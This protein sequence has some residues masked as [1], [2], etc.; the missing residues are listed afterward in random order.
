[1]A[2]TGGARLLNDDG[3][4]V[5]CCMGLDEGEGESCGNGREMARCGTRF[6]LRLVKTLLGEGLRL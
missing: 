6:L 1:M 5:V 2:E 3:G 4:G